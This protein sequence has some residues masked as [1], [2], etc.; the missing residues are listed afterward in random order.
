M[1]FTTQIIELLRD[2]GEGAFVLA[3]IWI[4]TDLLQTVVVTGGFVWISGRFGRGLGR[5]FRVLLDL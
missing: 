3:V 2:G 4:V 5:G 1:E